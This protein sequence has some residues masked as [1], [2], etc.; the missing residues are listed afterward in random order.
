MAVA[1]ELIYEFED[2]SGERATQAT[3]LPVTPT[4]AQ[5]E[6]FGQA[7][8]ILKDDCVL[9][10]ISNLSLS[11]VADMS[12]L[13]GNSVDAASDVEDIGAFQFVT[14]D[15]LPVKMNLPA[16]LESLV[17]AGS[18]DLDQAAPAIAAIITAMESGIA[19]TGGTI[20][21]C[22]VGEIDITD[23]VYARENFRPSGRRN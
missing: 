3:K 9:G 6:E 11:V 1:F 21:P 16:I 18:D 14:A 22:D 20:S 2:E 7:L 19:V 10:R 8:A 5:F 17:A 12:G 13:T 15:G 4:L 23:V